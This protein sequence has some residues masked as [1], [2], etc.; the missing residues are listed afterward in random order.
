MSI[1]R[2]FNRH[3]ENRTP[4]KAPAK[5]TPDKSLIEYSYSDGTKRVLHFRKGW[6]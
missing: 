2:Q 5:G 3:G 4:P 6:R 1:Q